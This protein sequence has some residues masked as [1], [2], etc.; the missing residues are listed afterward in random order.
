MCPEPRSG[1]ARS[2]YRPGR[3]PPP[4]VHL[5]EGLL[6]RRPPP[7]AGVA[8]AGGSAVPE[9]PRLQASPSNTNALNS[10]PIHRIRRKF[11]MGN[12]SP[13]GQAPGL[14]DIVY[15]EARGATT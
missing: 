9:P 1:P 7:A 11:S 8:P 10:N 15:E 5:T 14:A 2:E 6:S 13:V 12:P 4:M 3:R